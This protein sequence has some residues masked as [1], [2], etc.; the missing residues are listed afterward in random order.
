MELRLP[1]PCLVVLVGASGS[2]K[3]TW[4]ATMFHDSE[5]VSSDRLRGMVGA[6]EDDQQAGTAALP[7]ST[8]WW[9]SES[10]AG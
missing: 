5:I 1:V 10:D 3:S 4:A 9:L 6:G 7:S 8:R 2:G